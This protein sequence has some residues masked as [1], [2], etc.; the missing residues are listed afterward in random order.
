MSG[1]SKWSTIKHD[2]GVTDAKRGKLFSRCSKAISIAVREGG[3][4]DPE[5]NPKLRLM[6]EKAKSYNM[7][8]E[9]IQRA[10]DRG[11]G[12]V[13][14]ASY[15]EV[16]YE[17]FGPN[18]IAM[19]I[20]CVTDNRNRTN[21]EIKSLFDKQGGVLGSMGS[22]GYFFDRKGTIIVNV[23]EG[24]G[25]EELQLEL[26]DLGAEDFRE[27]GSG[28]LLVLVAAADT[29]AVTEAIK[30]SGI[31][32]LESEVSMV[33]NTTIELSEKQFVQFGKFLDI[34]DDYED[35]QNIYHNAKKA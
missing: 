17:G 3:G 2:K 27:V 6:I 15:E 4:D 8:K 34:V 14:G 22:T 11:A 12:R 5:S 25:M 23:P 9:N 33:P 35:V 1:H 29:H 16:M 31:E 32:V 21:S 13:E 18:K 26:I 30:G 10:I 19:M 28:K 20:E 7:P 24:K